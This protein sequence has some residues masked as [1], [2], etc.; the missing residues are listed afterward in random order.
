MAPGE[1]SEA[2]TAPEPLYL[3]QR[4]VNSIDLETGEDELETPEALRDWLAERGLLGPDDGVSAADLK[5]AIDV[6]EGLR[7]VLLQNNGLPLDE[8]LVE[9]LDRAVGRASVRVRF[10]PGQEP[11]LVA[12]CSGI[13]GAI[14]RLMAIVAAAVEHGRWERL[15]ACPRE[16]CEWAFYDRSKNSSGRWCS[17]ESCGNIEK[18]RAFRERKRGVRH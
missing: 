18:A 12:S 6:R 13:D 2:K 11:E 4:F 10:A 15:K 7:A 14:A 17:M 8:E 1:T 5:R 9:R 16:E 3:V